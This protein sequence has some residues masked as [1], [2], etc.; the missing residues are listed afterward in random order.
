MPPTSNTNWPAR[1]AH[2]ATEASE[3]QTGQLGTDLADSISLPIFFFNFQITTTTHQPYP[4]HPTSNLFL[5]KRFSP[6]PP[7]QLHQRGGRRNAYPSSGGSPVTRLP[8]SGAIDRTSKGSWPSTAA[9]EVGIESVIQT[10]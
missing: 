8:M 6:N 10:L 5:A 7:T 2:A 1:R 9:A 3:P 4:H